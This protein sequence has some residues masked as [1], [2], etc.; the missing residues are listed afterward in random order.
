MAG[1]GRLSPCV[2]DELAWRRAC[3]GDLLPS[4]PPSGVAAWGRGLHTDGGAST[5]AWRP[6]PWGTQSP[7]FQIRK[8]NSESH[9]G[10]SVERGHGA[11]SAHGLRPN[12]RNAHQGQAP[13]CAGQRQPC[14]LRASS[15]LRWTPEHGLVLSGRPGTAGGCGRAS[16]LV[17]IPGAQ[18]PLGL[19]S[20]PCPPASALALCLGPCP[21]CTRCTASPRTL[22]SV[23]SSVTGAGGIAGE[24]SHLPQ[25]PGNAPRGGPISVPQTSLAV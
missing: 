25:R 20:G 4:S 1:A 15:P 21:V 13:V 10:T 19:P 9:R 24:G 14:P 7:M 8:P 12:T 3:P 6:F 22:A 23:S 5:E 16:R 11:D 18:S 2:A 17:P